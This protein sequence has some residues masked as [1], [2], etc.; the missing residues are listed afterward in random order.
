MIRSWD[1]SVR[2]TRSC[3][4]RTCSGTTTIHYG[5]GTGLSRLVELRT[6]GNFQE[7]TVFLGA[8]T[9]REK[10]VGNQVRLTERFSS[11]GGAAWVERTHGG[12]LA[13]KGY[14]CNMNDHRRKAAIPEGRAGTAKGGK[15]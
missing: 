9:I 6:K 1:A 15:P 4:V 3:R 7:P 5:F 14:P 2:R 13:E 11:L 8:V 10:I 12:G